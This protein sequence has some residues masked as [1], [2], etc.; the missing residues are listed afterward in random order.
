MTKRVERVIGGS[1]TYNK[2]LGL[3]PYALCKQL[4]PDPEWRAELKA[5]LDRRIQEWYS[6]AATQKGVAEKA[7]AAELHTIM[8]KIKRGEGV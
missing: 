3:D 8:E 2:M 4:M 6:D 5:R 1:K 7:A